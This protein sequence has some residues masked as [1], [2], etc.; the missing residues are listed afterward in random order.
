MPDRLVGLPAYT[1]A[2]AVFGRG[3]PNMIQCCTQPLTGG[4]K[5]ENR[6]STLTRAAVCNIL[7]E[8]KNHT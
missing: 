3:E 5:R 1:A 7:L 8:W 6:S 4:L 2:R